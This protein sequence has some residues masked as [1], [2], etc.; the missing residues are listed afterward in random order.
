MPNNTTVEEIYQIILGDD[1][2]HLKKLNN[3][4]VPENDSEYVNLWFSYIALIYDEVKMIESYLESWQISPEEFKFKYELKN[5]I[6]NNADLI[7]NDKI[8]KINFQPR[9][10]RYIQRFNPQEREDIKKIMLSFFYYFSTNPTRLY[11][12]LL[13]LCKKFNL[14]FS[15]IFTITNDHPLIVD[16]IFFFEENILNENKPLL[17]RDIYY[18]PAAYKIFSGMEL[19]YSDIASIGDSQ[20][21]HEFGLIGADYFNDHIKSKDDDVAGSEI[22][23]E[24]DSI[25]DIL[26]Q[27]DELI[28]SQ[29]TERS[30]VPEE[31]VSKDLEQ[32]ILEIKPYKDDLDYLYEESRWILY[33]LK[34]RE[35]QDETSPYF[36]KSEQSDYEI[37]QLIKKQKN[38]CKLKLRRSKTN[39]FVPRLEK[40]ASKLKLSTFE[41]DVLKVLTID[42]IFPFSGGEKLLK[43]SSVLSTK[44][45]D[46][47]LLFVDDARE[48]VKEKKAFLRNSKL[49]KYNLIQ[50]SRG[51]SFEETINESSVSI[52]NRLLE[53]LGGED[54]E[55]SDYFEGGLLYRSK[56]KFDS[57]ILGES[58]KIKIIEM[59]DNFPLFLKAKKNLDFLDIVN[60]G[61]SLVMLF[62]GPSGTG[63]TMSANAIAEYM[64][65]RILTINLNQGFS[66]S[67]SYHSN[68]SS[69]LALIFRESRIND[70]VLFFD[71]SEALLSNRLPDILLEIE[72]HEG[73][74]IFATNAS[75]K[76]DEAMRRRINLIVDFEEPGPLQRRK[77]W[78][79]HLPKKIKM[80]KNVD[81]DYIAKKFE[82]NGGLIK[83]AVFS[84]LAYAVNKSKSKELEIT[85]E[86]LE[87]G[88]RDQLQNKL[89]MSRLEEKRIPLRG[90]DSLVLPDE[91]VS[92]IKEIINFEKA[93]KVLE[94]EWG[95]KEVFPESTGMTVLFHGSSGNGKTVT[96]EAIAFET[97]KTLKIVNYA[98]V[99]S[100]YVGGTEKAL[101]ALLKES[102]DN[103]SILL[104]DEA[105]S[106]F[107]KRT[108]VR[109]SI[110]R[111]ANLETD[112]L[113]N[114]IERNNVFAILTTNYLES[115]DYAFFRRMRF[116]VE[117]VNP[118]YSLRLNLWKKLMPE[119]LPLSNNVSF[120]KLAKDYPFNGGDIKN[121]IIRAA[122]RKAIQLDMQIKIEMEDFIAAC[123][124][125]SNVKY[126][127]K[128]KM[129]G[130]ETQSN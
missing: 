23:E 66:I 54:F 93:K 123:K 110:D 37:E 62:V 26:R 11:R 64:N 61:N 56:V 4:K 2:F 111:Y 97:G 130:F 125:I 27:S 70:A 107:T 78:E 44:V 10:D 47:L 58:K 57:V 106:I 48:R 104:F 81:L 102:A 63:K 42:K 103:D 124:E 7:F 8:C 43:L 51:N 126:G 91:V 119:K 34:L 35:R 101:E 73:V 60:Y 77:I 14:D 25:E 92:T 36:K 114:L 117:F 20:I 41:K 49:V 115:I 76:I 45:G 50:V 127:G 53:Y 100:M 116:I 22:D 3:F 80:N 52:D 86:D 90:L 129:M 98:Q 75:F 69:I 84:S 109:N 99:V 30:Q 128:K 82:L 5:L 85:M 88:A 121:A 17:E 21:L 72:K 89:F 68:T 55:F 12:N 71:E 94:G 120:E 6:K 16:K 105:D 67:D 59:L 122:T 118:D 1:T 39:G 112:V 24:F 13:E 38:L 108:E 96:A 19:K 40:I 29:L 74:V 46:L 83:N 31:G 9:I 15:L 87:Y 28:S 79:I 32:D 18:K 65:K 113:L 33:L 95:F